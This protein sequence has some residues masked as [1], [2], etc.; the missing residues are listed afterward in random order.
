MRRPSI[1]QVGEVRDDGTSVLITGW[2]LGLCLAACVCHRDA[3]GQLRILEDQSGG[4]LGL[5]SWAPGCTCCEPWQAHEL[6][7]ILADLG[8]LTDP[9]SVVAG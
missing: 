9:N 7:A 5:S 2:G 1:F 3:T 8:F 4:T 6:A